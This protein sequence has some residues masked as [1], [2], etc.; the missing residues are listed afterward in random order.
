MHYNVIRW[1]IT[2]CIMEPN[3][4][5]TSSVPVPSVSVLGN[6]GSILGFRVFLPSPSCRGLPT[7]TEASQTDTPTNQTP[8][9]TV[10]VE[11]NGMND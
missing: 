5:R 6:F 9:L 1:F 7:R 11:V 4:N 3:R 2:P 8:V 10:R